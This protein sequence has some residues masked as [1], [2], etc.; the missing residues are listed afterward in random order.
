[1]NNLLSAIE[2]TV[3]IPGCYIAHSYRHFD[4]QR[5]L[6]RE[7]NAMPTNEKRPQ[8]A[9]WKVSKLWF[10]ALLL[11]ASMAG[12]GRE[13]GVIFPTLTAITPNRGTQGQTVPVTLTGSS[14]TTGA[15]INGAGAGITVTNATVVTSTTI[16]ATFAIAANATLGVVNISVTSSGQT[17][18]T[19][20]FTI[21][22]AFSVTSTVPTNG[23]SNV[24]INQSLSATF[25]QA[26]NCAT[27]TTSS[28]TVMGPSGGVAGTVNCA[29][30]TA[31]FAP[32]S[33]LA[34]NASYTATLATS[35]L[36]SLGDPLLANYVWSFSTEPLPV[37]TSTNP[38]NGATAVP[39]DQVLTANF[40]EAMNC[41]TLTTASFTL[42]APGGA[43]AGTVACS[44]SSAT[45]TPAS[46]LASNTVY[47]ATITTVAANVGGGA[48]AS[49]FVWTF[50]TPLTPSVTSTIPANGATFVPIN[51][52]LTA[53]FS[54]AMA[55]STLNASTFT[56]A[57]PGGAVGG[58]VGCTSTSATFT[59]TSPLTNNT[60]YTA[61]ITTGA[62]NVGGTALASNYSWTFTTSANPVVVSTIPSNGATGVPVN[63]ALTATFSEAV[64]CS[65]VT[66]S[67]FTL[68]GPGG[69]IT[70]VVSCVGS[71]ATSVTFTPTGLLSAN[72]AY[73]ATLTTGI[74]T[75]QGY[76]LT[77]NYVWAFT[78]AVA[79]TVISTVPTNGATAV[80]INQ[81][82]TATFSQVMKCSTITSS[83]FTLAGPGGFVTG[84]VVCTG[85][86]ATFTPTS[87]L[88]SNATYTATITT[89]A[90][91]G[92]GAP[93]AGNYVWTFA[94]QLNP[95]V[96]STLPANGATG[97]PVNQV[98]SATFSEPMLCSTITTATFTLTSP[99]PVSV[100][101]IVACAGTSATF[102]PTSLLAASTVYTATITTG[103]TNGAGAP[104]AS[105]YV[106]SFATV[107]GLVVSATVPT[108][109]ATA[110]PTDQ[111]L[112]VIFNHAVLC[113][114]VT[115]ST[116]TLKGPGGVTVTGTVA[117]TGVSATSA[118][119]TPAALL[120]PSTTYTAMIAVGVTQ[121]GPGFTALLTPY[122]WSF[123]TGT[124]T[125]ATPPTVTAV[126]PLNLA[127]GVALNSA[128][129]AQFDEAMDPATMIASTFTLTSGGA[130]TLT[131]P[132]GGAGAV[133]IG[134]G[135]TFNPANNI[136]T[137]VPT[138]ALTPLTC[139]AATV[140][141]AA[142]NLPDTEFL[143]AN[144]IWT[145]TTGAAP[146]LTPPTVISTDPLNLATDV[147]LNQ[148]VTATFSKAMNDNTINTTTFTLFQGTTQ[149]LGSVGYIAGSDT[150]RFVP[151]S[152]LSAGLVYTATI[153]TGASD[154]A[155]NFLLA[156][157]VWSFTTA[158]P[159]VVQ[160][161]IISATPAD[162]A[163]GI[164][165]NA[166]VNVTFSTAMDQTTVTTAT[167][168]V[169]DPTLAVVSG[170]ITFDVT[171][172]IA[173]FTPLNPLTVNT[174]YTVTIS[175]TV[176]DLAGNPLA[177]TGAPNP[178]TFTTA[179]APCIPPPALGAAAPFGG[180]GGGAGMT[181]SGIN[182]VINGDIGTTGVSTTMTGFHDT[183]EPYIQFSSGCIYTET[184]LN[185]GTVNGEIF[186]DPPAPT[187]TCPNEGTGPATLP[188]TTAYVAL[189][190]YN[191]AL[192]T[193]NSLAL[194]PTTGPD[195]TG[196]TENLGGLTIPPGVYKSASGTFAI[197]GSDLTLDAQGNANAVWVF[198]M[199]TSLTVGLAGPLGARNVILINGAQ[200][201]N[202]FW[203]VGSSATINAAGGGTFVGTVISSAGIAVSTAGN[204][205]ITTINGRLIAL[206]ASTTLVNTVINVPG[207]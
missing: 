193:Y 63:Q 86:S 182:T 22:P 78:T 206:H 129:T 21:G 189:Q 180:F 30:S 93:L 170:V 90:T 159:V 140:T 110:V 36:D 52:V 33:H 131:A 146:D 69:T 4:S 17:T 167:F 81:I 117:C 142:E 28:F 106:W 43:V 197:S 151:N 104:L 98:L 190:A 198:Q 136:I 14:F 137:L 120:A 186:T 187:I 84:S 202:V 141:T 139:Y 114:T 9:T 88:T 32:T 39:V 149:I 71:T 57:G 154:L 150:A 11:V 92:A 49:N 122:S 138:S 103:A 19:V 171:G 133:S 178:W 135:V 24:L 134:G 2:Q 174:V 191:A 56:L 101:G 200:A 201:A 68:T 102:T 25:S 164:C 143:A 26:V 96:T 195:P 148:L 61:T 82:L 116:Y 127:T 65:T 119:F 66:A 31:T 13:Q 194:M 62:T 18:T 156:P 144:F 74:T 153:T 185:V 41:A 45:F 3:Q 42:S 15:T 184:T 192:A 27:V 70:G 176:T 75:P 97:V 145:F 8:M 181:N 38:T 158:G 46:L 179:S 163:T 112:T 99:G 53:I 89:A 126:T 125:S 47:T 72:A 105:N 58:T 87:L 121:P 10:M 94:T 124:T 203:Q 60:L 37:V 128:V 55:C 166:S 64:S 118:T 80:P 107:G 76:A 23:A 188:G 132:C 73:T 67:T 59:P 157:Y 54:E 177:N 155:G 40:S 16:T 205:A 5:P 207:Q 204:A 12:C 7:G 147:P 108:N 35:V 161:T 83:S 6:R 34:S 95:T 172:T 77:G 109:L 130:P 160:P 123:T 113:S 50:T 168:V 165:P 196:G 85:T 51:Q 175:N 173:T 162:L 199:G 115:T 183:T 29:G 111:Y 44:G 20:P 79:P 169:T 100:P 48:L 1:L 91:N 152:S